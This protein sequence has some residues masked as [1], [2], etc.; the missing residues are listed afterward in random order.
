MTLIG[1]P[2]FSISGQRKERLED[3]GIIIN[4][5][6]GGALYQKLLKTEDD[7][8]RRIHLTVFS[9]EDLDLLPN[10]L[11]REVYEA[12][13]EEGAEPI[14]YTTALQIHIEHPT[15]FNPGLIAR[16]CGRKLPFRKCLLGIKPIIGPSGQQY[17]IELSMGQLAFRRADPSTVWPDDVYWVFAD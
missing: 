6:E 14:P 3:H 17:V 12:A 11:T 7:P 5:P 15:M 2:L 16:L 10:C 9:L 4:D 13:T 8:R 1:I